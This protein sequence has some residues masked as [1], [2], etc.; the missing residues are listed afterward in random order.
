MNLSRRRFVERRM[1]SLCPRGLE[2]AMPTRGI[3]LAIKKIHYLQTV[4]REACHAD[5]SIQVYHDAPHTALR[6]HSVHDAHAS[7]TALYVATSISPTDSSF[8]FYHG[9]NRVLFPP[10]GSAP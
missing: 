8:A 10:S 1:I 6:R 9:A 3:Y 2:P 4:S 7:P 5:K